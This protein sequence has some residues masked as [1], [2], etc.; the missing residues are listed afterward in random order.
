MGRHATRPEWSEYRGRGAHETDGRDLGAHGSFGSGE[1]Q[2]DHLERGD[3][4]DPDG[5]EQHGDLM[6]GM[7][8]ID[9]N[10]P[11]EANFDEATSIVEPQGP[12]EVTANSGARAGLDNG[13]AQPGEDST[14][15]HGRA[16]GSASARGNPTPQI[17]DSSARACSESVPMTVSEQE[18]ERL[19]RAEE[20]DERAVLR[21]V[22]EKLKAG[23]FSL[24]EILISA[25][26]LPRSGGRGP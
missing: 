23:N 18:K 15:E 1:G 26:T 3:T 8:E 17:P 11:S 9:E 7:G 21:M 22:E 14:P 4:I 12:I 25:I 10:A 6:N 5:V 16:P 24:R 19:R 2:D 13:A 20:E